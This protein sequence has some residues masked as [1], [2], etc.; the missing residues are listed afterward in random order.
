M[1]YGD[2]EE[3]V[4]RAHVQEPDAPLLGGLHSRE[5]QSPV[6]RA[7]GGLCMSGK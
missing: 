6:P 7:L 4:W 1:D 3:I 5:L 2:V